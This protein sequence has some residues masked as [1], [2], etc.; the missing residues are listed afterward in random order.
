MICL[1]CDKREARYDIS[2]IVLDFATQNKIIRGTNC[3]DKCFVRFKKAL[4][5]GMK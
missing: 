1:N 2:F 5:G 3:C 4:K